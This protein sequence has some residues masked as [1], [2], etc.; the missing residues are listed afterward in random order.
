MADHQSLDRHC[1]QFSKLTG[2]LEDAS[3]I[4]AQGQASQTVSDAKAHC[5]ILTKSIERNC[6]QLQDLRSA[7][8]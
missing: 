4:A 3:L 2:E 6:H 5:V 1:E 7:F 8:E